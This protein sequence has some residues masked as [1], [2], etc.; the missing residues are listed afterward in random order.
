MISWSNTSLKFTSGIGGLCTAGLL[1]DITS[2][3]IPA[4]LAVGVSLVPLAVF[5]FLHPDEMPVS[6]VRTTQVAASI[7]Y[8]GLA[9]TLTVLFFSSG[10]ITPGWPVF[11]V[12]LAVGA[13]P[14]LVVLKRSLFARI[15]NRDAGSTLDTGI[16][17][18]KEINNDPGKVC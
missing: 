14:C 13:V 8:L 12:G 9:V 17:I 11:F 3:A 15:A 7:W 5:V 2:K 4:W 1:A 18:E 16:P 10:R 6:L